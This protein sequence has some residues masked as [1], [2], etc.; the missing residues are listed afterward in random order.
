MHFN[1]DLLHYVWQFRL[2]DKENHCTIDG[3]ALEI[4]AVGIHNKNAGPD[5]EQ[6]KIRIG[7]ET[8]AGNVEIHLRSS[9]WERHQHSSDRAYDN[10]IL[11]VVY[12]H[13]QEISRPD[14]T[15]IP[16][17]VLGGRI[18]SDVEQKYHGLMQN[19]NWIPCEKLL[20]GVDSFH[21][22]SWLSRVLVER[23]ESKSA[24]VNQLLQQYKGS[25]DDA[26][27]VM[28][29]RNFGFKTNSA[30][31]E[32]FARSLPQQILAKHKS[33]ASQIEAL[34]FGQSGFLNQVLEDEYPRKLKDEYDFLG[35]KYNLQPID[36]YLWKFLRLR[37]QNFPTLR[38]AQFAALVVKSSY[39]FAKV[40]EVKDVKALKAMFSELPVNPYWQTHFRFDKETGKSSPQLGD[41]SI[42]NILL[43]TVAVFLFSY[44]RYM[45]KESYVNRALTLL[46]S[47]PAET[48][49]IIKRFSSIGLKPEQADSSQA[50]LQLKKMYC[51]TKKCLTCG[52]GVKLINT[53]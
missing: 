33:D 23:L 5:F 31:F 12:Q 8:W 35:K 36:A 6:A 52:I 1:E 32:L 25:W 44:G 4:L 26:F 20:S 47:L 50:L 9:D 2:F 34:V 45:G 48:N 11:H 27:Y 22:K 49:H 7:E 14:G 53:A 30:P 15:K 16:V 40:V 46:E 38:L 41:D 13:D 42:N 19:L 3:E 17:L 21:V 18:P 39:L 29:A 37:P 10:V 43:N 51:D 24:E 28:L